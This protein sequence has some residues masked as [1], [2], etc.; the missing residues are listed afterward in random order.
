MAA[1]FS[2]DPDKVF[3][4]TRYSVKHSSDETCIRQS[5]HYVEILIGWR[6]ADSLIYRRK[7]RISTN[8]MFGG[9]WENK[10]KREKE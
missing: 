6:V 4:V 1:L 9:P 3:Y 8:H 7:Y 10:R 5:L 2:K